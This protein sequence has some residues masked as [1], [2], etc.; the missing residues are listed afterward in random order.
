MIEFKPNNPELVVLKDI[1]EYILRYKKYIEIESQDLFSFSQEEFLKD[2]NKKIIDTISS[3]PRIEL[4]ISDIKKSVLKNYFPNSGLGKLNGLYFK[5][6]LRGS[7]NLE[8]IYN[9]NFNDFSFLETPIYEILFTSTDVKGWDYYCVPQIRFSKIQ[10]QVPVNLKKGDKIIFNNNVL[11]W[12]V[13]EKPTFFQFGNQPRISCKSNW[14]IYYDLDDLNIPLDQLTKIQSLVNKEEKDPR[15]F[16][17]N[18]TIGSPYHPIVNDFRSYRDEILKKSLLG[19]MFIKVYYKIGPYLSTL[20]K[21]NSLLMKI[22][23]KLI[24]FIHPRI[25]PR[26]K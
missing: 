25:L 6:K 24:L 19:R 21:N 18:T 2:H 11:G 13:F 8:Q 7:F 4:T 15:C 23:R 20:I 16:V 1:E 3:I 10:N 14:V 26:I 12:Y 5:Q 17:V 22:S 9:H